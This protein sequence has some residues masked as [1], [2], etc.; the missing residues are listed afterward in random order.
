MFYLKK[1]T[2]TYL[3]LVLTY[4]VALTILYVLN[5]WLHHLWQFHWLLKIFAFL[6]FLFCCYSLYF[7]QKFWDITWLFLLI[8]W[9]IRKIPSQNISWKVLTCLLLFFCDLWSTI[10]VK[11]KSLI[12]DIKICL[13]LFI[14][15]SL[16][17]CL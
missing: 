8:S 5:L 4:S 6:L 17:T 15:F 2:F 9:Y 12:L 1:Y 7:P 10:H 13:Y 14:C 16:C 3:K 11:T